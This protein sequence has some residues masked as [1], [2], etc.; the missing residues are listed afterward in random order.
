MLIK[1]KNLHI[2]NWRDGQVKIKLVFQQLFQKKKKA[3]HVS[4]FRNFLAAQ[5]SYEVFLECNKI[6]ISRHVFWLVNDIFVMICLVYIPLSCNK[7]FI[8]FFY[9]YKMLSC[10]L[11]HAII[12]I[13]QNFG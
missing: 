8:S 12:I 6:I 2:K 10:D 13:V 3:F 5:H 11:W 1:E 9:Y 7:I 4:E